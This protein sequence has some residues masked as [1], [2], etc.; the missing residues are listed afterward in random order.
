MDGRPPASPSTCSW[1]GHP[2]PRFPLHS[3]PE[4]GSG[5]TPSPTMG[6]RNGRTEDTTVTVP[7]V[8]TSGSAASQ[9]AKGVVEPL[10]CRYCRCL[11]TQEPVLLSPRGPGASSGTVLSCRHS[12][13]LPSPKTATLKMCYRCSDCLELGVLSCL[14]PQLPP[15]GL[16]PSRALPQLELESAG[17]CLADEL[18]QR[19]SLLS[20]RAVTLGPGS[21]KEPLYM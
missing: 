18:E 8:R 5:P 21:D 20:S 7:S 9:S 19:A 14:T 13:A 4:D 10:S 17:H 3:F 2:E 16:R 15:E 12:L 1:K 6:F 11:C